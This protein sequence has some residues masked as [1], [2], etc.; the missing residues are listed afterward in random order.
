MKV[1]G[2]VVGQDR[3]PA[4]KLCI[5]ASRKLFNNMYPFLTQ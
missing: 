2:Y 3:L 1:V 5:A 4:T